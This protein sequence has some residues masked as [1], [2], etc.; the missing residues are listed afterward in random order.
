MK[1]TWVYNMGFLDDDEF[2]LLMDIAIQGPSNPSE[3]GVLPSSRYKHI[4]KDELLMLRSVGIKTTLP[5]QCIWS[6]I[7]PEKGNYN[8]EYLDGYVNRAESVGMKT[9]LFTPTHG[10]PTWFPDSYFAWTKGNKVH[11]EAISF[12][13]PK[14]REE[15]IKFI[16]KMAERYASNTCLIAFVPF[17]AGET[18]Y[19]N[20]PAFYDPSAV[21]SYYR[22]SNQREMLPEKD[23]QKTE[24]WL[25]CSYKETILNYQ[26]VVANANKHKEIWMMLHPA[27]ADFGGLYGNGNKWIEDILAYLKTGIPDAKLN[28]IYFTWV[29]W[30]RYWNKMNDWR[31]RF[32]QNVFGG[33]EYAEGL[34]TTTPKAIENGLRGQILAPCYP[35]IHDHIEPWMLDKITNSINLFKSKG[36]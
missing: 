21:E 35:N 14:A 19:L 13:N 30:E 29:Q 5:F 3:Y 23:N 33:A 20:E 7:E 25:R 36:A 12:W 6:E 27:I 32:D 9:I 8:W 10:F 34:P 16:Q 15:H 17:S 4:S 2:L 1:E 24:D 11:R 18:V 28:H 31:A 26:F 22:Y